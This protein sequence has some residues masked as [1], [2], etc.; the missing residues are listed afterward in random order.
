LISFISMRKAERWHIF[1]ICWRVVIA[2]T[3]RD[4]NL[5]RSCLGPR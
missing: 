5:G 4:H 3:R 1:A 2:E